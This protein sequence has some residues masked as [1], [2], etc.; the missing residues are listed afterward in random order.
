MFMSQ[1][2]AIL[3]YNLFFYIQW[4]IRMGL[5]EKWYEFE[6]DQEQTKQELIATEFHR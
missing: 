2:P 5:V 1:N 6:Q 4:P 3:G